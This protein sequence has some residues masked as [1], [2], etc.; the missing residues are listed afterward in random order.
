MNEAFINM[1]QENP[2]IKAKFFALKDYTVEGLKKRDF[3]GELSITIA[4]TSS[5]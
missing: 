2:D 4:I 5:F 1:F 3:N